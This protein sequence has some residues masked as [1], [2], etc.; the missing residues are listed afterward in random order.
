[1]FSP[2][3]M[4]LILDNMDSCISLAKSNQAK[5]G[6]QKAACVVDPSCNR[7]LAQG[8]DMRHLHPLQHATMVVVD[9]VAK[10]QSGGAWEQ[11][12]GNISTSVFP[13]ILWLPFIP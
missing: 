4:N 12:E 5:G 3:E 9:L 1:M 2:E 8:A 10:G 6:I 11:L 7:V 13:F